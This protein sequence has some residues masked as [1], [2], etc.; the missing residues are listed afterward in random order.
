[1]FGVKTSYVKSLSRDG[2]TETNSRRLAFFS[3]PKMKVILLFLASLALARGVSVL[4]VNN[5][6]WPLYVHIGMGDGGR[7]VGAYQT[8]WGGVGAHDRVWAEQPGVCCDNSL[9]EIHD[10][11]GHSWYDISLVDGFTYPIAITPQ[12]GGGGN[13]RDLRCTSWGAL[14]G[15]PDGNK[16]WVNG[17]VKACRNHDSIR[18]HMH[19]WCPTAYSWS[20]DDQN[21]MADT[22][23][24]RFDVTFCPP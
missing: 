13:R 14:D 7:W 8:S 3:A 4:V 1:M 2:T 24:D 9:A 10:D 6:W 23:A 15:C 18:D 20:G 16:V 11:N 17:A 12:G 19:Y 21:A 5:C 22:W